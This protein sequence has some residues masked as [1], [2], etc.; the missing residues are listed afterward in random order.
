MIKIRRSS[1]R[2]DSGFVQPAGKFWK[3]QAAKKV[4]KAICFDDSY[5][6]KLW[7]WFE[8]S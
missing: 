8:W 2:Y 3:R 1:Y 6:K 4:R 7:G 5:Y